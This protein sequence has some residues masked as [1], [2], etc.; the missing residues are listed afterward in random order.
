MSLKR[1]AN[2]LQLVVAGHLLLARGSADQPKE[3]HTGNSA[4][5]ADYSGFRVVRE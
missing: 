3:P 2:H 4:T 1:F 5:G